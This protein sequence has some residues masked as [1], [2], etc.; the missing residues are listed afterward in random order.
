MPKGRPAKPTKL[1]ILEGTFRSDRHGDGVEPEPLPGPAKCPKHL[2][3]DAKRVW[4]ELVRVMDGAGVL[5]QADQWIMARFC[6]SAVRLWK[7]EAQLDQFSPA[8][9][10]D[11]EASLVTKRLYVII[12]GETDTL[13]ALAAQ[14]GLSPVARS[15]LQIG[16]RQAAPTIPVRDRSAEPDVG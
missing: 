13:K 7:Y 15:Q 12:H 4:K 6:S 10:T 16:V 9:T 2:S 14:L 5:T 1:H 11:A 8:S 3:K